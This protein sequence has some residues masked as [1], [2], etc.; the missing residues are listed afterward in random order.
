MQRAAHG[1]YL[2]VSR[3]SMHVHGMAH[4]AG[5]CRAVVHGM[6]H[7]AGDLA[8]AFM[9]TLAGTR[10]SRMP[11]PPAKVSP[12][13]AAVA[14]PRRSDPMAVLLVHQGTSGWKEV[15]RTEVISNN[16]SPTFVKVNT[17]T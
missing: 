8:C 10:G 17:M 3:E 9:A 12:A 5:S 13:V 2:L 1:G 15:G 16:E 4:G 6:A 14:V 7:E 11:W